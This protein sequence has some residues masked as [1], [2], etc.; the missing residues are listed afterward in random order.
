MS[1]CHIAIEIGSVKNK[2]ELLEKAK[3]ALGK[4]KGKLEG[5]EHSGAF[6]LSIVIGHIKGNYTID[7]NTFNLEVLQRLSRYS[8]PV[9]GPFV[10]LAQLFCSLR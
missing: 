10:R 8:I 7:D 5:D 4:H 6:D 9:K 1:K 2:T 3:E